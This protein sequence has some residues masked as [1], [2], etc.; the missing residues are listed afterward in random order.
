MI[1]EHR[2]KTVQDFLK[3]SEE[4]FIR[5]LPDLIRWHELGIDLVKQGAEMGD[6]IWV[7]DGKPGQIH[8]V[9]LTVKETG[10]SEIIKGPAYSEVS[11]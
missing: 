7:D 8:S 6:L 4:E 9:E 10:Q 11:P 1:K 3:L 5:M 2:I